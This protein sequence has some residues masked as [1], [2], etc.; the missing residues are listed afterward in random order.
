MLLKLSELYC[1]H[2]AVA[3]RFGLVRVVVH[4]QLCYTLEGPG[5]MLS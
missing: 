5:A 2:R 1:S 4:V 3:I